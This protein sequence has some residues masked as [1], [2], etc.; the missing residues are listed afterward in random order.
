MP[1]GFR[2]FLTVPFSLLLEDERLRSV[3]VVVATARAIVNTP[4]AFMEAMTSDI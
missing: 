3:M 2:L 1:G 4:L